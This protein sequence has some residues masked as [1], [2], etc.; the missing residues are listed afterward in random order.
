MKINFFAPINNL[1]YGLHSYYLLKAFEARG[2]KVT[3]IPP[4][5][6]VRFSDEHVEKWLAARKDFSENNPSIMIFS[7]DFLT[8]FVGSPRIGFPVFET[9]GFTPVQIA[10]LKSCRAILTPTQ[11]GKNVLENNGIRNVHVV[12]EGVDTETFPFMD[13]SDAEARNDKF[14][15]LHVGKFE[16]RKGTL[17]VIEAF[18]SAFKTN[19]A[20]LILHI[21]NPFVENYDPLFEKMRELGFAALTGNTF[22]RK[23]LEIV[24]SK[25]YDSHADMRGLYAH[26]DAAVFPSRAEGWG[27]PILEALSMGIPTIVG[28][29]TAMTEYIPENYPFQLKIEKLEP[30]DDIFYAQDR[31][32]WVVPSMDSMINHMIFIY[33]YGRKFRKTIDWKNIIE[34]PRSFTWDRAAFQLEDAINK[35]VG[36]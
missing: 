13:F 26:A 34:I 15:F 18:Y 5:G 6:E 33:Q 28:K 30:V 20:R 9:E 4:L 22:L 19:E 24:L 25:H 14:T 10:C 7:E 36:Y 32:Q 3:L 17:E 12:N 1:G 35:I 27:L 21:H 16:K 31:G 8:Q 29:W 23:G 2:H 11:W